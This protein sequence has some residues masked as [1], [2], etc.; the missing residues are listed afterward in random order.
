MQ[1]IRLLVLLLL[2]VVCQQTFA[3]QRT[4]SGL[5]IS[6]EDHE[7]LIGA[8][9]S[10]QGNEAH[11]VVTDIDGKYTL[12]V[13]PDDKI[14]VVAYLG[15]KTQL[16]KVPKK[17]HLNVVLQPETMN[18][19][20]V[21]VTGY[22]NFTKSSF[23][24]S[25]N[26]LKGDMMKDIPVM[27]VEQKLQGMTMGVSITSSSGQPGANQSIR[28]RGMGSFNASQ[29]PLFVIDGVPEEPMRPI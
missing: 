3:Q 5:V 23:T 28:I 12:E 18:L 15:M 17:E 24:G 7:P 19:E 8:T 16:I 25:A 20:E 10:V 11:G 2:C 29:E 1:R 26:T 14:L 27:S 13:G 6:A 4:I 22:G 21:V 9:I